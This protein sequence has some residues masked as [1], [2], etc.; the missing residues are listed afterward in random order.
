MLPSQCEDTNSEQIHVCHYNKKRP[1]NAK[2]QTV[3]Y[4]SL[5]PVIIKSEHFILL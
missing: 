5:Y 4:N 3:W 1:D 2:N